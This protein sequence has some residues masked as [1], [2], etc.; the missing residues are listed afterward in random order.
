MAAAGLPTLP[1]LELAS[2]TDA[3]WAELA[4]LLERHAPTALL[5]TQPA[6]ARAL[7]TALAS[8]G[9]LTIMGPETRDGAQYA[10]WH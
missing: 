9:E 3:D 8:Q 7:Q 10:S 2:H 1:R 5:C 6:L 4:P